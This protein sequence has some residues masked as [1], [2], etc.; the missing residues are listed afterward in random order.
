MSRV[1][2]RCDQDLSESTQTYPTYISTY[3]HISKE[4]EV[5]SV[6]CL[7]VSLTLLV[8]SCIE[9]RLCRNTCND[10]ILVIYGILTGG[11]F[12]GIFAIH[13]C[14]FLRTLTLYKYMSKCM[15]VICRL[16]V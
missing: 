10:I 14:C 9:N 11:M 12:I 2:T 4:I 6:N 15:G 13:V 16:S 1:D 3:I 8:F 5:V 7:L